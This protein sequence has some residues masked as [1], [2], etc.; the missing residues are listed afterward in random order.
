MSTRDL[1]DAAMSTKAV[2]VRSDWR[3]HC[4]ALCNRGQSME[5]S[6]VVGLTKV[7]DVG[8]YDAWADYVCAT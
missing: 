4:D 1:R 3:S 8:G 2:G 6:V 7:G 5:Q